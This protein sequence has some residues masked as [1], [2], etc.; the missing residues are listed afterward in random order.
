MKFKQQITGICELKSS[1]MLYEDP[2][3][4]DDGNCC[5][6]NSVY[7]IQIPL[8]DYVNSKGKI[9]YEMRMVVVVKLIPSVFIRFPMICVVMMANRV[10]NLLI[11]NRCTDDI[12]QNTGICKLRSSPIVIV[13]KI[14][15]C[16]TDFIGICNDKVVGTFNSKGTLSRTISQPFP[17]RCKSTIV[18]NTNSSY[19]FDSSSG[20]LKVS[21]TLQQKQQ[22]QQQQQQKQRQQQRQQQQQHQKHPLSQ[23]L[24]AQLQNQQINNLIGSHQ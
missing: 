5:K 11:Y 17:L 6:I 8:T 20:L 23:Q 19:K 16:E 9:K 14:L 24:W 13:I 2:V 3:N 15:T 21:T 18:G 10:F 12:Q 1:L 7:S 4:C 22:Q